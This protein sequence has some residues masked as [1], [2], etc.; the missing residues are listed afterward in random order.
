MI[1]WVGIGLEVHEHPYLRGGNDAI[2]QVGHTFSNE[3]GLYIEDYVSAVIIDFIN[4]LTSNVTIVVS[5]EWGWKIAFISQKMV[6]P[7]ISHKE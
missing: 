7:F 1:D 2:I 4:V 6:P 5:S 3:P